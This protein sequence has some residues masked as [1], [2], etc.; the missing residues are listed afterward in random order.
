MSPLCYFADGTR[1]P[2]NRPYFEAKM[3]GA[4]EKRAEIARRMSRCL[5]LNHLR[6]ARRRA[7]HS[8]VADEFGDDDHS[9]DQ[10]G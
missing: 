10:S 3:R 7:H 5:A 9:R 1:R 2:Q 6:C 4:I 8:K